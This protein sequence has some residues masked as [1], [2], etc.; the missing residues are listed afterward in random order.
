MQEPARHS[1]HQQSDHESIEQSSHRPSEFSLRPPLVWSVAK[2]AYT[3][4]NG[5]FNAKRRVMRSFSFIVFPWGFA[6]PRPRLAVV[7]VSADARCAP[8]PGLQTLTSTAGG[9]R[10]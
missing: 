8:P 7:S 2:K 5:K 1:S 10:C 9:V 3:T 4:A 6:E